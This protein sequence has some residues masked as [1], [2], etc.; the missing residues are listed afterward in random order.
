MISIISGLLGLPGIIYCVW[1]VLH[2]NTVYYD[3]SV[4][5]NVF[6]ILLVNIFLLIFFMIK[7]RN[8]VAIISFAFGVITLFIP[9]I[10]YVLFYSQVFALNCLG[11][12]CTCGG[13]DGTRPAKMSLDLLQPFEFIINIK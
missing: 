4:R 9:Q 2:M 6:P 12:L 7:Y 13:L 10:V 5:F 1:Y 8:V 11:E 3:N